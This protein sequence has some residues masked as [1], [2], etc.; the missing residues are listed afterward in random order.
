MWMLAHRLHGDIQIP[1][2]QYA[3]WRGW[4]IQPAI[5]G[6]V[7]FPKNR[8]SSADRHSHR[9]LEALSTIAIG[10]HRA[11]FLAGEPRA[12]AATMRETE[13]TRR[14]RSAI[15][16]QPLVLD[17]DCVFCLTITATRSPIFANARQAA[18]RSQQLP[19]RAR[20]AGVAGPFLCA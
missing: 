17:Y 18:S 2:E 3:F 7:L 20:G 16:S 8:M 13:P 19:G 11:V 15:C 4:S 5:C 6:R 1:G 9:Q 10:N 14:N 12:R